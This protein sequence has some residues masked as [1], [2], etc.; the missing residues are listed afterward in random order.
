MKTSLLGAA[1]VSLFAAPVAA[2]PYS[3][4]NL[5]DTSAPR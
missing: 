2:S 4:L 3:N 1:V 5:S